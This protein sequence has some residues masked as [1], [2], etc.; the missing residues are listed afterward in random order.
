VS[1]RPL[2]ATARQ[3]TP[4]V[5]RALDAELAGL[6]REEFPWASPHAIYLDAA[7]TGPLPERSRRAVEA[8]N[9][10]RA[11]PHTLTGNDLFGTLTE[12]RRL[13]GRLINAEPTEIALAV[14]TSF[15]LAIAARALPLEPG[16]IV[17]LSDREF[18]A[19]VYPWLRLRQSGITV[20][21]VPTTAEG[22]PDQ[23]GLLERIGDPRVRVVAVS[24]TQFHNGYT[25][26]LAR[27]SAATRAAGSYL[28]VDAIQ[29]LGQ[30]PVDVGAVQ[31]DI[32]SCG[33]QKWL[34]SPW[35]SGFF[36]VRRELIPTLDPA[37]TGWMAF[38]GTDDF[39]QM[40]L[41]QETLRHDARR[42]E[43]ISLPFQDFVGMNTSLDLL[44]DIGPARIGQ[45]LQ[46]VHQPVL[47]W[48]RRRSV[49]IASP[50]GQR[51]SGILAVAPPDVER[52]YRVLKPAGV[53]CSLREGAIRLSPHWYNTVD[54]LARVAEILDRGL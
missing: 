7:S 47:E 39:S 26:D 8:F 2:G 15:G 51:G 45:H 50:Q 22:W 11:A 19:N 21:L 3:E 43:L 6:R 46:A 54:D 4:P 44:M 52:H 5:P 16:D 48:A 34:L 40:T 17:L 32:L 33:A 28:V 24:L 9:R 53:S 37:I 42:F 1:E 13:A 30:M 36:Y 27:I 41:Y 29:S 35:G 23:A 31:V 14:N 20:E 49:R 18:P 25:V 12:S 38:E 10:K